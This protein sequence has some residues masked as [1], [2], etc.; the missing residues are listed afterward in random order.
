MTAMVMHLIVGSSTLLLLLLLRSVGV[1]RGCL[2][3]A[4]VRRI[5]RD[6]SVQ[7]GS[8]LQG[9]VLHGRRTVQAGPFPGH[10]GRSASRRRPQGHCPGAL[11]SALE[12]TMFV[13][14]PTS[15]N[16]F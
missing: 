6:T 8:P 10:A 16:V 5:R 13:L 4:R 11:G 14:H 9:Y 12:E 7:A 2:I 3:Y 1:P 15:W